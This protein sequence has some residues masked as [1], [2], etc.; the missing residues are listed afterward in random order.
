MMK[1]IGCFIFFFSVFNFAN[2][3]VGV[4]TTSPKASLD[5]Q[6]N[7]AA[8]PRRKSVNSRD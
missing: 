6:I 4:N 8:N 5:I 2:A 1:K 3:Q 7:D